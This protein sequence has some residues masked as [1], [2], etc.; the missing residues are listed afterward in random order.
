MVGRVLLITTAALI[1]AGG[2]GAAPRA[3]PGV[4]STTITL[5]GSAPFSGEA[6]PAGGVARGADAYFK[7]VNAHGGVHGRKITYKVL[8][9][10]YDPARTVENTR[11]LV[12]SE[13]VF[14]MFGV[15]GTNGNLAI[16]PF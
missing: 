11:Q 14:G 7:W 8:D 16:R 15:I 5:G 13:H 6:S 3:T 2:A 10:A 12:Q 4:T 9:D 1:A